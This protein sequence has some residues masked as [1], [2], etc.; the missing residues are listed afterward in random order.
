MEINSVNYIDSSISPVS[1]QVT[2]RSLKG[3][4]DMQKE[5]AYQIIDMIKET[6]IG[7]N[8]DITV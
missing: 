5:F 6:G 2:M 1:Q 4:L 8:V 3:A 7:Q